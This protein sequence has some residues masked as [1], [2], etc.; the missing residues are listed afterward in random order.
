[1]VLMLVVFLPVIIGV[2]VSALEYYDAGHSAEYYEKMQADRDYF[3]K[4]GRF[5]KM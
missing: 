4:T 5:P 3:I 2:I 1:M